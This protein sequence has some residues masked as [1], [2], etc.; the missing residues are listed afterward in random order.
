MPNISSRFIEMITSTYNIILIVFTAVMSVTAAPPNCGVCML[1]M[2]TDDIAAGLLNRAGWMIAASFEDFENEAMALLLKV[3]TEFHEPEPESDLTP[4]T[5]DVSVVEPGTEVV[6]FV[7]KAKLHYFQDSGLMEKINQ[8]IKDH[9]K[10]LIMHE[11][12]LLGPEE[13]TVDNIEDTEDS[14]Q[15]P[16]VEEEAEADSP[17]QEG[18]EGEEETGG[19]PEEE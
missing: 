17:P 3:Y 11:S 13:R 8:L 2:S 12:K 10:E 7:I 6:H 16:L 15:L 18:E 14:P 1:S 5:K 9:E 4:F 19:F